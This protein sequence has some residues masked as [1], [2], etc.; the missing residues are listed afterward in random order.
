MKKFLKKTWKLIKTSFVDFA[1]NDP[2]SHSA[3]IAYYTIFSLPGIAIIA[4]AVAAGFYERDVARE[5]FLN[6]IQL[7]MGKNSAE[8]IETLMNKTL[9]GEESFLMKVIGGITLFISTTTVFASLQNSLNKIW[10]IKPKPGKGIIKFLI[11]RLL[12]L[13]MVVSLGFLLLVSLMA[14]TL[15]AI[16]KEGLSNIFQDASYHVIWLINVSV[17]ALIITLIFASIYKVLPDAQVKWKH[18]WKGAFVTTLLF[19]VGKFLIG[20]YLG[21]SDLSEAYGAAG[22][23]VALLTWVYYSVI[24]VLFGAQFTFTYNRLKGR[25]IMPNDSAVAIEMKEIERENKAITDIS[26][27]TETV[28]D[29]N[30]KVYKPNIEDQ[31]E[32]S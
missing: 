23:L 20:Y 21:Q 30:I 27:R 8:Q 19:V 12:S 7:V 18:V 32:D 6:Q 31:Q 29:Q 17:S 13:A 22:S 9:F 14:D 2:F 28:V 4:V 24:I 16:L 3:S 25:T 26:G 15:I 10:N 1:D 5:E 11:T